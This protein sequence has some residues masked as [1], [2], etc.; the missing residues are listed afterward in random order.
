MSPGSFS[1]TLSI[2]TS[3]RIP[4]TTK[5]IAAMMVSVRSP[6]TRA[7]PSTINEMGRMRFDMPLV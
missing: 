4:A 2:Y 5:R 3:M 7:A 1:S 6:M